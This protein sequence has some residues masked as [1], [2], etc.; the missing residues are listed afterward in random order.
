MTCG[1]T[2]VFPSLFTSF[3]F[4]FLFHSLAIKELKRSEYNHIEA[5]VIGSRDQLCIHPDLKD[6]PN[7]DKILECKSL[8]KRKKCEYYNNFDL[9]ESKKNLPDLDEPITDIEDLKNAGVK[10]KCC[11]YFVAK[12]RAKQTK[13]IFMPYNVS[14]SADCDN[15]SIAIRL[16]F[17]SS[18][19]S[20]RSVNAWC[21]FERY[22]NDEFNSNFGRGT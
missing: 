7:S 13:V 18:I 10:H 5:T 17:I 6:L 1:L 14:R 3:P 22:R 16:I 12:E 20:D 19:V 8:R 21:H 4:Q 15:F 11:P 2:T 9:L